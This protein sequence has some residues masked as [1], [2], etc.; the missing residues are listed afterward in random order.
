LGGED[1][2]SVTVVVGKVWINIVGDCGE[3]VE[4]WHKPAGASVAQAR[5]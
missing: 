2:R 4:Y 5:L 3:Q 1:E